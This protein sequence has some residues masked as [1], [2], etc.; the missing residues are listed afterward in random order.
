MIDAMFMVIFTELFY[1]VNLPIINYLIILFFVAYLAYR[2][3]KPLV[4]V[5]APKGNPPSKVLRVLRIGLGI[6][7]IV[8]DIWVLMH[9]ELV[10]LA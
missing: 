2:L 8:F 9:H 6:F 7:L 4:A 3:L 10:S 1:L 5:K